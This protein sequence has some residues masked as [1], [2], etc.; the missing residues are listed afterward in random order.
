MPQEKNGTLYKL[1]LKWTQK[2]ATRRYE[3]LRCSQRD[4]HPMQWYLSIIWYL[5]DFKFPQC[6]LDI[7]KPLLNVKKWMLAWQMV[8]RWYSN[9]YHQQVT[10][11]LF[12]NLYLMPMN[13]PMLCPDCKTWIQCDAYKKSYLSNCQVTVIITLCFIGNI[14]MKLDLQGLWGIWDIMRDKAIMVMMSSYHIWTCA[15]LCR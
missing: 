6:Y 7:T 10:N 9:K 11:R 2:V 15:W 8:F 1:V 4:I 12:R 3:P 13:T 14:S 5:L